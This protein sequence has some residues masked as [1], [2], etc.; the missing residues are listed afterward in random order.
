MSNIGSPIRLP[1]SHIPHMF[2]PHFHRQ[3]FK[4]ID[5]QKVVVNRVLQIYDEMEK[6]QS[7]KRMMEC[8]VI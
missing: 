1:Q 6:T 7:K 4:E 5:N 8:E 2:A 3:K